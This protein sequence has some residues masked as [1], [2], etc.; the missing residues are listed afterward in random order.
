[1]KNKKLFALIAMVLLGGCST[2]RPVEHVET[3]M[4]VKGQVGDATIGLDKDN[5][6][7]IQEKKALDEKLRLLRWANADEEQSLNYNHSELVHCMKDLAN[8]LLDGDGQMP[9]IPEIDAAADTSSIKKS[10][11][12]DEHGN[13]VYLTKELV[14]DRIAREEKYA[15]SLKT[16]NAVVKGHLDKCLFKMG[17]A[18]QKKGLSPT[19]YF[20]DPAKGIEFETDLSVAFKNAAKGRTPAN[21]EERK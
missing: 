7:I 12:L 16:N 9:A 6:A 11:G 19:W 2:P 15:D 20:A 5:Q 13:L 17:I 18:R 10:F 3:T 14:Q 8:P 4:D 1:M 21:Q